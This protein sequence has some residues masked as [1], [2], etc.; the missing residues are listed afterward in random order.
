MNYNKYSGSC[1]S[2][3]YRLMLSF[4]KEQVTELGSK[5]IAKIY[6]NP[7]VLGYL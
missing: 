6:K 3:V 5:E 4:G 7:S 2:S 1:H